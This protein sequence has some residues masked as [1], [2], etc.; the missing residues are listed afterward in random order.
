MMPLRL[1][2]IATPV[3][4]TMMMATAPRIWMREDITLHSAIASTDDCRIII[5]HTNEL[6]TT[7][8]N[9]SLAMYTNHDHEQ[10]YIETTTYR[11]VYEVGKDYYRA[12]AKRGTLSLLLAS[13][14]NACNCL[15]FVIDLRVFLCVLLHH[16]YLHL[17]YLSLELVSTLGKAV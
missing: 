17:L 7:H 6:T 15:L 5:L 2:A 8:D 16:A 10:R 13:R 11:T 14:R 4:S 12:S 1:P 9:A 3:H